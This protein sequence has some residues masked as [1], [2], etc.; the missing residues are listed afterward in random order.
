VG[1]EVPLS[2]I[3]DVLVLGRKRIQKDLI[4]D[5]I[6]NVIRH[7]RI[8][9]LLQLSMAKNIKNA[10][11][12]DEGQHCWIAVFDCHHRCCLVRSPATS[13]AAKLRR[14]LVGNDL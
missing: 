4:E 12:C 7:S 9:G 2:S 3:E 10:L 14:N 1:M 11:G 8:R 5:Q 6:A 13:D